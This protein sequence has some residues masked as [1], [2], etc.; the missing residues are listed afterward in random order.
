MHPIVPESR[1][2]RETKDAADER[3][4]PIL[5][6]RDE[7]FIAA[8]HQPHSRPAPAIPI[9]SA[10]PH[11]RITPIWRTSC[12]PRQ[13][14]SANAPD[15]AT[16]NQCSCACQTFRPAGSQ[17]AEIRPHSKGPFSQKTDIRF[18][19]GR[20]DVDALLQL[21]F[22]SQQAKYITHWAI[23][24]KLK[25]RL[26]HLFLIDQIHRALLAIFT[27]CPIISQR[28]TPI[29]HLYACLHF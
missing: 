20:L 2:W 23:L 26:L 5:E 1:R 12:G 6:R 14:P 22:R 9:T 27:L 25:L 15:L 16:W 10:H 7:I 29:T 17:P 8:G 28:F 24:V 21:Q 18:L 4:F 3:N 11:D 13:P 19:E